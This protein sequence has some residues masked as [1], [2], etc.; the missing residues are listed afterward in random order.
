MGKV[1]VRFVRSEDTVKLIYLSEIYKID[2]FLLLLLY[3]KL[4][5]DLFFFFYLFAGRQ[6]T[7]PRSRKFLQICQSSKTLIEQMDKGIVPKID[8]ERKVL[9]RMDKLYSDKNECFE[10]KF[11]KWDENDWNYEVEEK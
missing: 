6:V 1:C 7:F 4:G 10:L 2:L 5:K 8:Q 11:S 3:E 9:D